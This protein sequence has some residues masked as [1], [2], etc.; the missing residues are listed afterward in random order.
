MGRT[1]AQKNGAYVVKRGIRIMLLLLNIPPKL[2]VVWAAVRDSAPR[3]VEMGP[4]LEQ[5]RFRMRGSL[6][7]FGDEDDGCRDSSQNVLFRGSHESMA[8]ATRDVGNLVPSN[9]EVLFQV[10]MA[11]WLSVFGP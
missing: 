9:A 6:Q 10:R 2:I 3:L 11:S 1:N 5:G 7:G 8:D 4:G